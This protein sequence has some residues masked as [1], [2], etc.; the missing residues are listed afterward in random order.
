MFALFALASTLI[1]GGPRVS[2]TADANVDADAVARGVD[3]RIGEAST[4][5]TV[6]IF[7]EDGEVTF[8]GRASGRALVEQSL[9]VPGEDPLQRSIAVASAVAFAIEAAP[10]TED[11]DPEPRPEPPSTRRPWWVEAGGGAALNARRDL[12][13]AGGFVLGGGRWLDAKQH[14]R[15]GAA[16]GWSHSRGDGLAVHAVEPRVEAAAGAWLGTRVWLGGGVGLGATGAWAVDRQRAAAWTVHL[17]VPALAE[18]SLSDRWFLRC[19]LGVDVRNTGL[20]FIGSDA[21]LRWASVRPFAGLSFGL[22][23]P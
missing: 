4:P 11:L 18:V 9:E 2:A 20:R 19:A 10:E 17:R 21:V 15:L 3:A 22:S 13:L 1:F 6:E 12:G 7:V 14:A 23:L 8:R 16:V 5:W